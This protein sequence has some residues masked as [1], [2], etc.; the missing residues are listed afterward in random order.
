MF[1]DSGILVTQDT[2]QVTLLN[3]FTEAARQPGTLYVY[4][5]ELP[6]Y[7]STS[8]AFS[9]FSY[10]LKNYPR[11][12]V[13]RSA[14]PDDKTRA[15]VL[16]ILAAAPVRVDPSYVAQNSDLV[17]ALVDPAEE[18]TATGPDATPTPAE[19]VP[20]AP[21]LAV[22]VEEPAV[23]EPAPTT[24]ASLSVS[25]DKGE[26]A[27]EPTRPNSTGSILEQDMESDFDYDFNAVFSQA[28]AEVDQQAFF[29][30]DPDRAQDE[31]TPGEGSGKS[32]HEF[33]KWIGKIEATK[34]ALDK[35][36]GEG[37]EEERIRVPSGGRAASKTPQKKP[38][39]FLFLSTLFSGAMGLMAAL[40]LFP[41]TVYT[42]SV[43]PPVQTAEINLT[44][45]ASAFSSQ[46]VSLTEEAT[47][48]T[49]GSEDSTTTRAVGRAAITN[50][51]DEALV[52][53][54]GRYY[55]ETDGAR[56]VL[57]GNETL[58]D[59]IVIPPAAQETVEIPIQA[60]EA[61]ADYALDAGVE[62]E[63][64][65][66][67]GTTLCADCEV[68]TTTPIVPS[69]QVGTRTVVE[70]DREVLRSAID[71]QIA[72]K[73]V[74][75]YRQLAGSTTVSNPDWF[76]NEDSEYVF[77]HGVGEFADDL[78]L[79]VEVKSQLYYLPR[80]DLSAVLK[81][82]NPAVA[83][84]RDIQILESTGSFGSDENITLT[85]LYEYEEETEI[86][87]EVIRQSLEDLETTEAQAAIQEQ[88]PAVR[89]ISK[90]D[91]GVSLPGVKPRINLNIVQVDPGE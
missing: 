38:K 70:A 41:N 45:P 71:S 11:P 90:Q 42:L 57:L 60:S 35:M 40:I 72:Q 33:D 48:P 54:E 28:A 67:V 66:L 46:T 12:I 18:E 59:S 31:S 15:E 65:D 9:I 86:D 53:E 77:N 89:R 6:I 3:N 1:T 83:K 2:R 61:G 36:K 37:N 32:L 73:R 84:V 75:T 88:F 43:T 64:L 79:E 23:S 29:A 22:L 55:L 44:V 8:I 49:S 17:E 39:T 20:E 25:G 21:R 4:V 14:S 7:L 62:M 52:L 69:E 30:R 24:P 58:P 19:S 81:K 87:R 74:T 27:V 78:K 50:R 26:A 13:W 68:R 16:Q 10:K 76:K 80:T 91:T 85:L 51:T 47:T 56:Y 34:V 5:Q 82:E 63:L